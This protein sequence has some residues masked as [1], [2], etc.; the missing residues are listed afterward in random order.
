[1]NK[2]IDLQKRFGSKIAYIRKSQKLSQ[3]ELAEK[4]GMNANYL[5]EIERGEANATI[6]MIKSIA[7]GLEVEVKELFDFSF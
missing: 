6:D 5:G 1:M 2:N 3:S 4:V 7:D